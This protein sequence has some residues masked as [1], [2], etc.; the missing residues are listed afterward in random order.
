MTKERR[1]RLCDCI[2]HI[3]FPP[4][5]SGEVFLSFCDGFVGCLSAIQSIHAH[6]SVRRTLPGMSAYASSGS[7]Y[8]STLSPSSLILAT[9]CGG[10][11]ERQL[12]R[13]NHEARV[14]NCVIEGAIF[15]LV[16]T[17]H[18]SNSGYLIFVCD[19]HIISGLSC[20][21]RVLRSS[22]HRPRGKPMFVFSPKSDGVGG[23]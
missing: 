3:S 2:R 15:G 16:F 23:R 20:S 13:S 10:D 14:V 9:I 5:D 21:H 22:P 6:R 7:N 4:L 1:T 11:E 12:E 19:C 17:P 8:C 18:P